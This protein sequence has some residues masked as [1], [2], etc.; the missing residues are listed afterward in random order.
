MFSG[1]TD[2][3]FF[4]VSLLLQS[5]PLNYHHL[6]PHQQQTDSPVSSP[7]QPNQ[8]NNVKL[9]IQMDGNATG[10]PGV[11]AG[12]YCTPGSMSSASPN[13][14]G[15]YLP[16]SAGGESH[17]PRLNATTGGAVSDGVSAHAH[18]SPGSAS[19][20]HHQRQQHASSANKHSSAQGATDSRCDTSDS[21]GGVSAGV[22]GLVEEAASAHYM[23][24]NCVLVTYFTGE[25][26]QVIDE[27][28]AR[29]LSA[30][31]DTSGGVTQSAKSRGELIAHSSDFHES[32]V[33]YI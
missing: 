25:M 13:S 22:S 29:A 9:E 2:I 7:V 17:H 12:A 1:R 18:H 26:S 31:A 5:S 16:P 3:I 23:N 6:S 30:G 15:A 4:N 19:D 28:F 21:E 11:N 24:A 20:H 32:Y 8:N 33:S 27:H 10:T 14:S